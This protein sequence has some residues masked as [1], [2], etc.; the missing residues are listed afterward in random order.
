MSDLQ[1]A[2]IVLGAALVAAVAIYNL[3]Q[4]RRARRRAEA[5]F[6]GGHADAL[7]DPEAER[8]EPVLGEFS[9]D[10]RQDPALGALDEVMQAVGGREGAH[11][12]GAYPAAVIS[13]RIDTIALVLA[14]EPVT[15]AQIE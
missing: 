14:D 9:D 15:R 8:R 7:L 11:A 6:R 13:A 10:L 3:W 4:E 12:P 1:L 2:L 5:A